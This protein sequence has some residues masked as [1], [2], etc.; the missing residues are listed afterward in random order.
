MRVGIHGSVE[1]VFD[2]TDGRMYVAKR[3][4]KAQLGVD[5]DRRFHTKLVPAT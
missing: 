1:D 2:V 3:S 4:L 5:P